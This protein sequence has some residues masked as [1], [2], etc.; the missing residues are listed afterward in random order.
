MRHLWIL[1]I[2]LAAVPAFA[3]EP[4]EADA[5]VVIEWDRPTE[6][7]DGTPISAEEISGYELGCSVEPG[8]Y[9]DARL[10][11]PGG[12]AQ[13]HETSRADFLPGYGDYHC[14]LRAIDTDGRASP[15]SNEIQLS[16]TPAAPGAPVIRLVIH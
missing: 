13:Q 5:P 16:W 9:D 4:P 8:T 2:V 14:A 7:L 6:R 15:W 11:V 3:Q 1:M 10:P 12:E